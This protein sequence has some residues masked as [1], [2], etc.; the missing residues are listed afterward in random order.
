MYVI[1][2]N[3]RVTKDQELRLRLRLEGGNL[4]TGGKHPWDHRNKV[5]SSII[6]HI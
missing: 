1:L 2:L 5:Y 6:F 4:L 3:F